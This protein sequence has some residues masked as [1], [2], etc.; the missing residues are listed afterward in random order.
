MV[1]YFSSFIQINTISSKIVCGLVAFFFILN[2]FFFLNV[3]EPPNFLLFCFQMK[4]VYIGQEL[5][6]TQVRSF[7]ERIERSSVEN[8]LQRQLHSILNQYYYDLNFYLI[9]SIL[10]Q[11]RMKLFKGLMKHIVFLFRTP[12]DL[13]SKMKSPFIE[14]KPSC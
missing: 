5:W 9:I 13:T 12:N 10:L 6:F 3:Q 2:F 14:G 1:F 11:K 7:G 4:I 8:P